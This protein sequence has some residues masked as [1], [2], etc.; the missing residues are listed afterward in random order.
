MLFI[1]L[2][3]ILIVLCS[4][5]LHFKFTNS[6]YWKKKNIIQ[7]KDL[8]FT[9]LFNKQSMPELIKSI[10]DKHDEPY[11]GT[12]SATI[13]T[14]I[15]KN[16]ND[17][18]AVL[19]GD[20]QSFYSR[21]IIT[22]PNDVLADNLLLMDDF[23]KW[24]LIRQ[25]LTPIFTSA[26]LKNMFYII[27]KSARDFVELVE[28]NV[29]LRKKPFKL[30][31]RYTTAS[32]SAAVFG[33]DT[34]VKNSMESP[35][36]DMAFKALEPS[37]YAIIVTIIANTF[38]KVHKL[39]KLKTFGGQE[40]FFVGMVKK[41]LDSRRHDT[42]KRHD[43]IEICLEL[44]KHGVMQDFTTGYELEPTDEL[45][46]AQAFAFYLAGTDTSA[47]TMNYT[48]LEL[49]NNPKI[50]R[51]VHEEIDKVFEGG[52]EELSY[53]DIDKLQYLDE[54][55]NEALRKYPPIGFM[56]RMCTKD[57]VLPSGLPVSKDEIIIVPLYGIHK[58]EQYFP[59]PDVFDPERFSAENVSKIK[60][61]FYLPFGEG[62]RVCIGTRFARLQV[63]AGLAWLLR[64]F[65]LVE[66]NNCVPEFEK[67]PFGLRSPD[68]HYEFKLRDI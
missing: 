2:L 38:P 10:Y 48:L 11:I 33:I 67:S 58:D 9:F 49:S 52:V 46:A 23:K 34:Q 63:K 24:K 61:Y 12:T 19:A 47:N 8:T 30:M 64:R 35:L 66:Q 36:V 25:K 22:S 40:D 17:I 57:T 42:T 53:N 3:T 7:I 59:D 62:N 60:N 37:V 6:K 28:D 29:H 68:A 50:L 14:L 44:Q 27:E 26:K 18:Q 41:V 56:Q 45:M 43:F 54:V 20:F 31:T 16:L 55:V 39:L 5:V 1:I 32:I 4:I 65:T 21:G 15:I 51:K 13:P